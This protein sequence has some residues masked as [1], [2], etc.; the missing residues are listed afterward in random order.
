M[1]VCVCL[2]GCVCLCVACV[3]CVSIGYGMC[4]DRLYIMMLCDVMLCDVMLCDA[5][6]DVCM[7]SIVLPG[8]FV[9]QS[10]D[11]MEGCGYFIRGCVWTDDACV[12]L[13]ADGSFDL[14]IYTSI[15]VF[16]DVYRNGI[17]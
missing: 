7:Y 1:C 14:L 2:Y 12:D 5:I 11:R 3:A 15:D 17:M 13:L 4:F 16:D 9:G 8:F 6:F 10:R